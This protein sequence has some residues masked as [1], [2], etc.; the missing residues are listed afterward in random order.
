MGAVYLA[1]RPNVLG[2]GQ[3]LVFASSMFGAGLIAFSFSSHLA[4]SM[5]CLVVAGLGMIMSLAGSNTI[6]QTIVDDDKRGRLMSFYTMSFMGMV[7]IG[8]FLAG[9]LAHSIG[10]PATVRAGGMMCLAGS[11]LFAGRLKS[12]RA[13]VRPIYQE[14]GILP[15]PPDPQ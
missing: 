10:A 3:L 11:M 6:L 8:S 15:P 9:A 5:V 14:K 4:L 2:M 1:T 12:I 7:P 13:Q